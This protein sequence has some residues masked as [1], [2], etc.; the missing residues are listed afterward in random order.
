[1]HP[2]RSVSP[3]RT[4]WR[5]AL[6]LVLLL[7]WSAALGP[8]ARAGERGQDR[9]SVVV[10]GGDTLYST[11]GRCTVGF[12]ARSGSTMY[13]SVTGRCAQGAGATWYADPALTVA[14][15]VTAGVS[16]PG[17][18][19]AAVRYTD[20]TGSYPGEVSLGSAGTRDITAAA[21]PVV[22]QQVCH[23]GRTTDYRCG[24]VQAVNVTVNYGGGIV[25]GLFRSNVCSEP[26][27]IGG[28]AFSGGTALGIIA[29]SSGNCASGGFTY[30]QPVVE[31]LS[32]YGLSIY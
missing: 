24:T 30:Y 3:F 16:Y 13:G 6:A 19:Y 31:W 15:G 20:T 10:H 8:D 29:G 4:A 2:V 27:D 7:G 32:A 1:M 5:A 12:N 25:Y 18:D 22:G 14:V 9:A 26:G 17:N 21:N 23:A 11:A 28:P